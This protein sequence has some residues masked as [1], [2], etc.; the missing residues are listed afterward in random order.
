MKLEIA[1][2]LFLKSWSLAE[3]VCGA[4]TTMATLASILCTAGEDGKTVLNATDLKTSI[5]CD[6]EGVT[7]LEP[8][9]AILPLK[10]VGELF[11]KLPTDSYTVEVNEE[12]GTLVSGR[13]KYK[14]ATYNVHEFPDLPSPQTADLFTDMAA[15]ELARILDEGA[16]AGNAADPFPK[17]LGACLLQLKAGEFRSVSTDGRRLSLSK[18]LVEEKGDKEVLLPL[19][20]VR[21]YQKILASFAVDTQVHICEDTSQVYF[22]VPGVQYAVRK[23]ESTFP[24]YEKILSTHTTTTMLVDREMFVAALERVD[25]MV[26]DHSRLV[27]MNLSPDGDLQLIGRA[28]EIGEATE[29]VTAKISGEPLKVGFNVGYLLDGLKAFHGDEVNLTFNGQEGQMMM[30]R[31]AGSDFLYMLMPV[32]LKTV[33]QDSSAE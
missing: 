17:Y 32:K 13:S 20:S 26:R 6:A 14:F 28:P 24:N 10:V 29:V 25:V 2:V 30:L 27:V 19:A 8:G 22:Q 31:P 1:K 18:S 16:I 33:E 4:R 11:K 5:S 7:V 9:S 15:G 21:E 23:V 3:R 12:K